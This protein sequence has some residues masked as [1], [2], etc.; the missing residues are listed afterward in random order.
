[1]LQKIDNEQVQ[2]MSN[3]PV[4]IMDHK[5]KVSPSSFIP[6]CEFG[7]NMS[8]VGTTFCNFDIPICTMFAPRMIDGQKCYTIDV[9]EVE[10]KSKEAERHGL[11]FAMDYNEDRNI[12]ED[13]K[14]VDMDK[15][16]Y[17]HKLLGNKDEM[18]RAKIYIETLG[19]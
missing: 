9:N 18:S 1:M 12:A 19:K 15:A 2:T 13:I 10:V 14:D 3:H 7:G 16:T 6:F 17:L 4:H 8:A 5:G 11:V